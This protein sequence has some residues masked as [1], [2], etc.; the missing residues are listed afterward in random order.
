MEINEYIL[1]ENIC[2][3]HNVDISLME[4]LHSLGLVK[5]IYFDDRK[6]LHNEDLMATEKM[7]R[8]HDELGVNPEGIDV[9]VNLLQQMDELRWQLEISKRRLKIFE[10]EFQFDELI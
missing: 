8:L 1:I 6:Y 10:G 9:I 7:I 4:S 3:H 5:F 2:T